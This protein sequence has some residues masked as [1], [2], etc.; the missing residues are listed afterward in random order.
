MS[1]TTTK[2]MTALK[3]ATLEEITKGAASLENAR[4]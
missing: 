4:N 3:A 2:L 1:E